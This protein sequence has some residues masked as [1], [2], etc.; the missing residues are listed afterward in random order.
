M[1]KITAN[2]EIIVKNSGG[3]ENNW[4]E[5]STLINSKPDEYI[6]Y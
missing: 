1:S 6:K 3:S 2:I 4:I 5:I